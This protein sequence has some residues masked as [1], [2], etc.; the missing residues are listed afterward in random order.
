MRAKKRSPWRSS[1]RRMRSIEQ[2]PIPRPT[3]IAADLTSCAPLE[4]RADGF[5]HRAHGSGDR[6]KH[7]VRDDRVTDVE[8]DD[9]GDAHERHDVLAREPV[10]RS[11]LEPSRVTE[12]GA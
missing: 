6:E 1:G 11:D 8:L 3:I 2:M 9:L 5:A 10:P 4:T 7:R 12:G